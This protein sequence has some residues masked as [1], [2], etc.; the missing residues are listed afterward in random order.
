MASSC[1]RVWK[2]VYE[3]PDRRDCR[4]GA[5]FDDF[6]VNEFK[7]FGVTPQ[8]KELDTLK[9]YEKRFLDLPYENAII[10]AKDG[11]TYYIKG[12]P[13]KVN[14]NVLDPEILA[15]AYMTHNHPAK[16]TRFSFSSYDLGEFLSISL[17]YSVG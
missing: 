1:P 12:G 3:K 16:E 11:R 17:R 4:R 7:Y 5:F 10:V 2:P 9:F 14:I 6:K 15:G 8:G 13:A